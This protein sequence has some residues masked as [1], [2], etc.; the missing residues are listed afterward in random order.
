VL[1]DRGFDITEPLAVR[2]AL[3][4]IPPFTKG[5]LNSHRGKWRQLENYIGEDPC[6]T[7]YWEAKEL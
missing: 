1:A 7:H 3:L 4:A 5:N 2:G 6:G